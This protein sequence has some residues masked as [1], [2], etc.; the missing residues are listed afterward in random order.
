MTGSD[1]AHLTIGQVKCG[2]SG[3]VAPAAAPAP[4]KKKAAPLPTAVSSGLESAPTPQAAQPQAP[5]SRVVLGA[6]GLTSLL[7]GAA[8]LR[9]R[10]VA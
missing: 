4:A 6:V 10:L 1:L 7:A 3:R 8:V 2:P 9:R 5:V